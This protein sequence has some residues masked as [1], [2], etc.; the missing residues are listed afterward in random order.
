MADRMI[1]F[2]SSLLINILVIPLN[3]VSGG[4]YQCIERDLPLLLRNWYVGEVFLCFNFRPPQI[5]NHSCDQGVDALCGCVAWFHF[6]AQSWGTRVYVY[7]LQQLTPCLS[8]GTRKFFLSK[9]EQAFCLSGLPTPFWEVAPSWADDPF[10]WWDPKL[11]FLH[12]VQYI[13]DLAVS[14]RTF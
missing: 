1:F 5:W 9:R 8:F 6:H 3:W 10:R 11:I 2:L 7:F 13:R 14:C 4:I 12:P